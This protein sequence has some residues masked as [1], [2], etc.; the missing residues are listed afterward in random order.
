[1][2]P[3]GLIFLAFDQGRDPSKQAMVGIL[4]H[5]P[6]VDFYSPL[7]RNYAA[8]EQW[9]KLLL[10]GVAGLQSLFACYFLPRDLVR[11]AALPARPISCVNPV[12]QFSHNIQETRDPLLPNARLRL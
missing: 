4:S 5:H 1:M 11:A 7:A 6:L 10:F 3:A 9:R 12:E 8:G 2:R